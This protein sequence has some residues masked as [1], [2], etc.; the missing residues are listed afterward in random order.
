MVRSE[1]GCL[2]AGE[3]LS[4]AERPRRSSVDG[5]CN[6]PLSR[7][8]KQSRYRTHLQ[9]HSHTPRERAFQSESSTGTDAGR[10]IAGFSLSHTHSHAQDGL[11]RRRR[12]KAFDRS[13]VNPLASLSSER[14]LYCT[15]IYP[16]TVWFYFCQTRSRSLPNA[17]SSPKNRKDGPFFTPFDAGAAAH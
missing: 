6:W 9:Y 1:R 14:E 17:L 16:P 15:C 4:A 13:K 11:R 7:E 12:A 8:E 3:A 5:Q 10:D 2:S